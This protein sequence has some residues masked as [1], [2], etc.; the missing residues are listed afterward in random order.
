MKGLTEHENNQ[1]WDQ[2]K[3]DFPDDEMMQKIHYVRLLH[4]MKTRNMSAQER[5]QFFKK[6]AIKH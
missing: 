2:V 6:L 5:I 4:Y 3:K 1:L